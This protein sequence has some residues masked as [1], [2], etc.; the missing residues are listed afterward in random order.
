MMKNTNF[1]QLFRKRGFSETIEILQN[2]PKNEAV[3]SKFF[4]KL[5]ESNS[6]PNTFFRV[7]GSLLKHNIIAYKLNTNNEKVI[8]L[9]EKGLD[10]WNRIQEIEKIL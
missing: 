3:Q 9:T 2:F 8:F 7:K 10:V 1:F 4:E 6:Y 5:V